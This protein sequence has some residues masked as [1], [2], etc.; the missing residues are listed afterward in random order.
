[1]KKISIAAAA[2]ALVASS[3]T[4][5]PANAAAVSAANATAGAECAVKNTV[6]KGKGVVNPTTNKATDISCRLATIGG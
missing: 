3:L 6:A 4:A 5:M 1:M 2:L